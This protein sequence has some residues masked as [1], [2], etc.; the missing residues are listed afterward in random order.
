MSIIVLIPLLVITVL[1]IR[2][3]HMMVAGIC[4]AVIAMFIGNIGLMQATKIVTDSLPGML[5]MLVPIIYCSTALALSKTGGFE[6]LLALARHASGGRLYLVAAAVVIIQALA[7]YAAGLAAGNTMAIGPL[8]FAIAGV[9][10]QVVAGMAIVSAVSFETSPS[11]AEAATV[12]KIAGIDVGTYVDQLFPIAV[13]FWLVGAALAAYGVWKHGSFIKTDSQ[14][15]AEEL[16]MAEN[17]RRAIAPIYFIAVVVAGKYFNVW[18]DYPVFTPIFNMISTLAIAAIMTRSAVA[19][20]AEDV[21]QGSAFIL[22]KLFSI[23]LFLGFINILSAIGTFKYIAGLTASAPAFIF[24]P[25]AIITGFAVA[26]PA[27]A[28]SVGVI[29]LI[30]PVLAEVGLTPLQMGLVSIA[31]GM[32]TQMSPVQINVAALSQTFGMDITKIVKNNAPYLVVVLAVLC[33]LGVL[34]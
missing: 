28:Y 27:G 1:L 13:A 15:Q 2:Q 9:V 25:V 23:G 3:T 22:T 29:S 24:V 5:T 19:K 26:V 31:I 4:G 30:M 6:A 18:L 16:P 20:V 12:S 8:A 17:W 32:G 21:I 10:P 7:T 14:K 34:L 11:S 33:V